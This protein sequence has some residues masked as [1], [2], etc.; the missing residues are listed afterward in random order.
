MSGKKIPDQDPTDTDG[1]WIVIL[2]FVE[3]WLPVTV[4]RTRINE[5][6]AWPFRLSCWREK[7]RPLAWLRCL[8]RRQLPGT[9]LCNL[10]SV[11]V[12]ILSKSNP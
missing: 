7:S 1:F 11:F 10:S 12:S 9:G 2:S 4:V 8:R 3:E 6:F 5:Y